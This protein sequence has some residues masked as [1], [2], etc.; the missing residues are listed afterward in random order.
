MARKKSKK[1]LWT[2]IILI[3]IIGIFYFSYSLGFL[4]E[5]FP[6]SIDVPL[7][8]YLGYPEEYINKVSPGEFESLVDRILPPGEYRS[9][10]YCSF[11]TNYRGGGYLDYLAFTGNGIEKIGFISIDADKNGILE[12]YYT[13]DS[14]FEAERNTERCDLREEV[15]KTPEGLKIVKNE[16]YVDNGQLYLCSPDRFKVES[17]GTKIPIENQVI[18]LKPF[19]GVGTSHVIISCSLC[20]TGTE[21]CDGSMNF[22]CIDKSW[23]NMGFVLGKCGFTINDVLF[24]RVEELKL[25]LDEKNKILEELKGKL[26]MKIEEI[27]DLRLSIEQKAK[28]IKDYTSNLEE[29]AEIIADLELTNKE[30]AELI[31]ELTSNIKDQAEIISQLELTSKQQVEYIEELTTNIQEQAQ[32]INALAKNLQEKAD[33]VNLLQ[34]ENEK[35]AELIKEM[36]LSFS[37]QGGIIDLLNKEIEDDAEIISS[38]TDKLD[39]QG[40]I[41]AGMKQTNKE[42]AELVN[43]LTSEVDGQAE[44]ISKLK[45]SIS[46]EEELVKTLQKK[47]DEQKKLLEEIDNLKSKD[48]NTKYLIYGLATIIAILVIIVLVKKK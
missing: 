2:F 27:N 5:I 35:Q 4:Q 10:S 32:M 31:K 8:S 3:A 6:Q 11:I 16:D 38:L 41:I 43:E 48:K 33:L 23:R 17:D 34:V 20:T 47:V 19:D 45:L 24:Q 40:E 36:R 25:S 18:E 46:Q 30:K 39:E 44:I 12:G 15:A 13:D 22:E 42:Q 14:D 29:Q 1:L 7:G 9:N 26:E 28:I 37:N 21:T